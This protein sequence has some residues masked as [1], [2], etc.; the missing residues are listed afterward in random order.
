MRVLRFCFLLITCVWAI[1]NGLGLTP[2][3]GW[4]SWNCFQGDVT[5]AKIR[6]TIDALAA[7]THLVDGKLKSLFDVGYIHVG[8]DDGW[9]ACDT[10]PYNSF[11]N[12]QGIPLVNKTRFTDLLSLTNYGRTHG[13][14]VGWYENNCICHESAARIHNET[15]IDATYHG[16][17]NQ[18]L[19]AKFDGVKLDGCGLHNN[20]T[21]YAELMNKTGRPYLIENCH[22]GHIL[23]TL[24]WCPFNIY[25]TSNDIRPSFSSVM[26]NLHTTIPFQDIDNP[27]SRPGCWAYPD[28]LEV[29]NFHSSLAFVESRSHFGAWCVVSAPLILGLDVTNKTTLDSVWEIITNPEAISVNQNWEGH[30]GRFINNSESNDFQVWAKKQPHGAQAVL[31]INI[32]DK[33]IASIIIQLSSL[34]LPLTCN[35]R[36]IWQRKDLLPVQKEWVIK[37]IGSH[38]SVFALFTPSNKGKDFTNADIN[39]LIESN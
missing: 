20:L 31:V 13:A 11:H 26:H 10:G 35:V 21:Y 25:R 18:L 22:G 17:V 30:P 14:K 4:R 28:M 33:T 2:P 29:G 39:F 32:S 24:E 1:D 6:L 12:E 34:D 8:I 19:N 27:L 3:M 16:D 37:N 23:P 9:Q 38:D 5:D 36:D 7:R 15:W